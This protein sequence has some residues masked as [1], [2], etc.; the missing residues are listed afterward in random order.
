MKVCHLHFDAKYCVFKQNTKKPIQDQIDFCTKLKCP[1]GSI[2][3]KQLSSQEWVAFVSC[4]LS[5]NPFDN[6]ETTEEEREM[7]Y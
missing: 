2:M 4:D 7:M 5:W 3:E 1:H 6:R